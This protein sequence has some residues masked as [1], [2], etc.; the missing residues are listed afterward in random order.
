[1]S[2][3]PTHFVLIAGEDR[4]P[5][6]LAML[7]ELRGHGLLSAQDLCRERETGRVTPVS[8]LLGADD[9]DRAAEAGPFPV[10]YG[11]WYHRYFGAGNSYGLRGHG[12]ASLAADG[13]A[14]AA[15][16]APGVPVT[17]PLPRIRDVSSSGTRVNF[18]VDPDA[19]GREPLKA[20]LTFE[21][22]S[23]R[24]SSSQRWRSCRVRG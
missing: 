10:R 12:T 17:V 8:D 23:R 18:K 14:L 11:D 2:S 15:D 3:E 21:T 1:M 22:A 5:Y 9:R 4:G 19:G 13:V 24:S 20:A 7:R 6:P 16:S